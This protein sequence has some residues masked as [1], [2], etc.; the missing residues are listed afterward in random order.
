[1]FV[2][3]GNDLVVESAFLCSLLTF[4][5]GICLGE[6]HAHL[7]EHVYIVSSCFIHCGHSAHHVQR[8]Y[9]SG[10]FARTRAISRIPGFFVRSLRGRNRV[11][12]L[13]ECTR[14]TSR[15][16]LF[17]CSSVIPNRGC[18]SYRYHYE[19]D[20]VL[21]AG[22][23]PRLRGGRQILRRIT[24]RLSLAYPDRIGV[25]VG[26]SSGFAGSNRYDD[27]SGRKADNVL[28][29]EPLWE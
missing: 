8:M 6:R 4:R 15:W 9:T 3:L 29:E 26:F 1:M 10:R 5:S 24:G 18:R 13:Q 7:V 14:Q 16:S 12:R 11:R 19:V 20:L 17:E 25:L 2:T 22:G 27:F 23:S 28:H 21:H